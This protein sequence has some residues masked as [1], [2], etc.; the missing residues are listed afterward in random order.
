M[1][2][3]TGTCLGVSQRFDPDIRAHLYFSECA[4]PALDTACQTGWQRSRAGDV[5]DVAAAVAV[6]GMRKGSWD[7]A[8]ECSILK[9]TPAAAE[10]DATRPSSTMPPL[11]LTKSVISIVITFDVICDGDLLEEVTVH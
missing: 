10:M 4:G 8:N 1:T 2:S 7:C 11:A 5:F 3:P 6:G 9:S